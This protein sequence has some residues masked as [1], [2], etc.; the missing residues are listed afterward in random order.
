MPPKL[1]L[2][3]KAWD[4]YEAALKSLGEKQASKANPEEVLFLST[5]G[6]ASPLGLTKLGDA[7][8]HYR[9]IRGEKA[10]ADQVLSKSVLDYPPASALCQ[11]LEGVADADRAKAEAVLRSQG[12]GPDLTD[13]RLGSLLALMH[14]A[15]LIHY[16]KS[17][18]HI[19]IL[20][21]PSH[22]AS[23]PPSVFISPQ[24]PYGNK[25]WLRRILEECDSYIYW[26]DKHFLAAGFESLWEA[27]D[28]NHIKEVR[29]LSLELDGNSGKAPRRAYHELQ[30]ELK[31]RGIILEWRFIDSKDVRGTHDRWLISQSKARNIPDVGTILAGN[32]SELN[33]SGQHLELKGIFEAYWSLG[34]PVA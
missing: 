23:V 9:F 26:F 5:L 21:K 13:R 29:I 30:A 25:V 15:G 3:N 14:R 4:N 7:Y 31:N 12:F 6:L 20:A 19:A 16:A 22:F 11:L 17:K 1:P 24:T 33:L 10:E 18:G 8:F 28:A 32:H 34:R 27:A 2:P